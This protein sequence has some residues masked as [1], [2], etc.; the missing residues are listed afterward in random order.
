[1]CVLVHVCPPQVS[2][3]SALGNLLLLP[4]PSLQSLNCYNL[5]R[6]L[7]SAFETFASEVGLQEACCRCLARLMERNQD[8]HHFIGRDS[9][10]IQ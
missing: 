5:L 10:K 9:P 4:L 1:M 8:L 3:L 2:G 6:L 7:H